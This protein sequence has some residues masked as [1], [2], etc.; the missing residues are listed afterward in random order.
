MFYDLRF[1][2]NG[3]ASFVVSTLVQISIMF[4]TG[5]VALVAH[6]VKRIRN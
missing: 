1:S 6:H 4:R 2:N 3:Q 5:A